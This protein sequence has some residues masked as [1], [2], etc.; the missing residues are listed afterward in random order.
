MLWPDW[1]AFP[2]SDSGGITGG[3]VGI[4]GVL[5]A[6]MVVSRSS[7]TVYCFR[8]VPYSRTIGP[9]GKWPRR[10][11]HEFCVVGLGNLSDA[12]D[13]REFCGQIGEICFLWDSG[14]SNEFC[15]YGW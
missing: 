2:R 12:S 8:P 15:F 11:F 3:L 14:I 4:P 1:Q 7:G 6:A 9:A 10:Y 5:L 13:N